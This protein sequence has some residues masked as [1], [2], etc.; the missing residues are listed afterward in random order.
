MPGADLGSLAAQAQASLFGQVHAAT[1]LINLHK[2]N[3]IAKEL[4]R[5]RPKYTIDKSVGDELSLAE[6][7]LAGGMSARAEDAYNQG[8]DKNFASSL[9]TILRGGGNVNSVGDIYG[10]SQAGR[11]R[12]SAMQDEL[13]LK[14]IDNLVRAQRYSADQADKAWT[15]N[16][17]APWADKAQANAQAR[18]QAV[19]G[20]WEGLGTATSAGMNAASNA[21][22]YPDTNFSYSNPDFFGPSLGRAT[23]PRASVPNVGDTGMRPAPRSTNAF[24]YNYEFLDDPNWWLPEIDKGQ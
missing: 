24:D 17:Y 11:L 16:Q 3:K 6:N 14:Q 4:G 8:E 21:G 7:E 18:Q 12:L 1:S 22:G 2:A 13:R 9:E 19:A 5:T 20:V 23:N 15:I 10:K